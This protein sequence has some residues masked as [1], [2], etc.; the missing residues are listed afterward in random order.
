[1]TR[2][3]GLWYGLAAVV[4]MVVVPFSASGVVA[5]LVQQ[6]AVGTHGYAHARIS[7]VEVVAPSATVRIHA[8]PAGQEAVTSTLQWVSSRP[9][10]YQQFNPRTG[11]L[12][13]SYR[14]NGLKFLS[15]VGCNVALDIAAP[16]QA[17]V[18]VISDSGATTVTGMAGPVSVSTTSG[19]ITLQGVSGPVTAK[20]D[21]GYIEGDNLLART[22]AA[23][24]FSGSIDLDFAAPPDSVTAG[25]D[26]GAVDVELPRGTQYRVQASSNDGGGVNVDPGLASASAKGTITATATSGAVD[27]GYRHQGS[28]Q[29]SSQLTP[30]GAATAAA[31]PSGQSRAG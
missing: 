6:Q 1:M 10:V 4:V 29:P 13:L 12:S 28:D 31:P 17:S 23:T 22:V 24:A 30:T 27:I 3:R 26:S 15:G 20:A 5:W 21:S 8:V 2:R 16:A 14:C 19:S 7:D 25:V 9:D 18:H 11:T